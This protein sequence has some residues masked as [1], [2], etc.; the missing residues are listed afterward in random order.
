MYKI[1]ILF[2]S[3]TS[4]VHAMDY[5]G[6]QNVPADW[7]VAEYY[8]YTYTIWH[9]TEY[10]EV[11]PETWTRSEN[12]KWIHTLGHMNGTDASSI[13]ENQSLYT[14]P[15]SYLPPH[16]DN[17]LLK[18]TEPQPQKSESP[19]PGKKT[20]SVVQKMWEVLEK[21]LRQKKARITKK[22]ETQHA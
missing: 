13:A 3:C 21:D 2:L 5:L 9:V 10:G 7:C 16:P 20:E 12:G 19:Q 6:Y 18:P 4:Y 22:S 1:I 17:R 11:I 15:P 8:K 14:H